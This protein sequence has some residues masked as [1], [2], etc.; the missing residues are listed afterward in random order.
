MTSSLHPEAE[1]Q[2]RLRLI[3]W[4][5]LQELSS[6][7]ELPLHVEAAP[8][9]SDQE[10]PGILDPQHPWQVRCQGWPR[11]APANADSMWAARMDLQIELE[12]WGRKPMA[13]S[14]KSQFFTGLWDNGVPISILWGESGM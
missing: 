1:R 2:L 8:S 7:N 11:S 12:V 3:H 13:Q 5:L 9:S 14:V 4:G 10:K 6:S